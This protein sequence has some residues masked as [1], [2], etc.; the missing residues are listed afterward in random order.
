MATN[1]LSYRSGTI[2]SSLNSRSKILLRDVF[3]SLKE[4]E[5]LSLIGESG[6]GK[7]LLALSLVQSLPI[8]LEE[9]GGEFLFEGKKMSRKTIRPL[10]GKEI[11]TMPQGGAVSLNPS[12]TIV[13]TFYDYLKRLGAK[14]EDRQAKM[15]KAL[16]RV[17]FPNPEE[18]YSKYPFELSGGMA[19]RVL[20][21]LSVLSNPKLLILDEPTNGVDEAHKKALMNDIFTLFPKTAKII[22]T[23]D[24]GLAR[25][26]DYAIVLMEGIVLEKGKSVDV[27]SNPLHPYTK[28]LIDSL[29]S[30][31]LKECPRIREQKGDCPF[32]HRCQKADKEC[33]LHPVVSKESQSH[34]WRCQKC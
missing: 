13:H 23:H 7:S 28:S 12:R 14:K 10:L 2:L 32:Y 34:F 15:E 21:A 30:N 9:I 31:G 8:G 25:Q 11:V 29:P 4:G 17:G 6:S 3:F 22:I 20:L 1:L 18:I 16:T 26:T 27:L 24:I 5:S 33:L 19:Q